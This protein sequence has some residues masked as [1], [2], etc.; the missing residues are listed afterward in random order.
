M[1]SCHYG[2]VSEAFGPVCGILL[3]AV[4]FVVLQNCGSDLESWLL[5]FRFCV[6]VVPTVKLGTR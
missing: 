5:T 1:Y 2:K 6:G 4:V 3:R